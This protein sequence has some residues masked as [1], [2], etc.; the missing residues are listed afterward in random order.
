[1]MGQSKG[2]FYLL[3]ENEHLIMFIFKFLKYCI[4]QKKKNTVNRAKIY[5][6]LVI[7]KFEWY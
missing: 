7:S 2:F 3:N 5:A 6:I 1:M 4:F